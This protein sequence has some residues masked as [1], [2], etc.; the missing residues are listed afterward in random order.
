MSNLQKI[1]IV[2]MNDLE[3]VEIRN[4]LADA[5]E[6]VIISNQRWGASWEGLEAEVVAEIEQLRSQNPDAEIV[7]IELYGQP[8]WEAARTVDHHMWGDDDS[9]HEMSSIEQIAE[10]I[11]VQLNRYQ[12]LVAGNDKAWYRGMEALSATDGEM[13]T[14]RQADR[15]SQGVTPDDEAQAVRDIAAAEKSG[16]QV[17]VTTELSSYQVSPISDRLYGNADEWLVVASNAWLYNGSRHVELFHYIE[18]RNLTVGRDWNGGA[19][20]WGYT[21]F[22]E[23]DDADLQSHRQE[24]IREFF[25]K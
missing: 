7:G 25:W 17:L 4:M 20:E 8:Q 21:G 18:E 3:A 1:W 23:V 6:T 12:Q 11:G 14:I 15:C 13:D 10:E 9:G 16:S 19:P 22:V 24:A 5:G 2:P